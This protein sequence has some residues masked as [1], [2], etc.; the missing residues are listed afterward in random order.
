MATVTNRVRSEFLGRG[1]Y[2]VIPLTEG[3][4]AILSGTVA[5]LSLEPFDLDAVERLS[6][7]ARGL[8]DDPMRQAALGALAAL[9]VDPAELDPELARLDRRV[10]RVPSIAIDDATSPEL[11]D[12]D[13]GGPIA[14]LM[15]ELG[16]TI[17][18]AIG[19][20]LAV[21]GTHGRGAIARFLLGSISEEVLGRLATATAIVR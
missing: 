19:P 14:D 18:A 5:A 6:R 16:S 9:G 12:E 13:D 4:D 2:Q 10:A 1:R 3:A 15:R 8:K 21:L 11:P 20:N 7:I 17:A